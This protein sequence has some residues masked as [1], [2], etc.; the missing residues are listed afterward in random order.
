MKRYSKL[1]SDNA[2]M[3]DSGYNRNKNEVGSCLTRAGQ[4]NMAVVDVT[5][6]KRGTEGTS[7][8][9]TLVHKPHCIITSNI[10]YA[11]TPHLNPLSSSHHLMRPWNLVP[12]SLYTLLL[13]A[14][15]HRISLL[16]HAATVHS[17]HKERDETRKTSKCNTASEV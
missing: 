2:C 4:E 9:S 3:C 17:K 16:E 15:S 13:Q 5:M 12:F 6:R 1:S 8:S 7:H 11:R 10:C 14:P